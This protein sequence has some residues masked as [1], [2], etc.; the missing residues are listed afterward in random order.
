MAGLRLDGQ[1]ATDSLRP[2]PHGLDAKLGPAAVGSPRRVESLSVVGDFDNKLAAFVPESDVGS[3]DIGVLANVGQRLL[4]N[5]KHL[6]V[7]CEVKVRMVADAAV[8]LH[9]EAGHPTEMARVAV[10]AVE[11][12]PLAVYRRAQAKNSLAHVR[13]D[14]PRGVL[15]GLQ[16]AVSLISSPRSDQRAHCHRLGI[17]VAE[18]LGEAV[19]ELPSDALTLAQGRGVQD[20]TVEACVFDG[21]CQPVPDRLKQP[22]L[23]AMAG[24]P[25]I[26][27]PR[28][29]HTEDAQYPAALLEWQGQVRSRVVA[30]RADVGAIWDSPDRGLTRSDNAS[31]DVVVRSQPAP[32]GA[33]ARAGPVDAAVFANKPDFRGMGGRDRQDGLK[34]LR[35]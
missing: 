21:E 9:P 10:K 23:I 34:R 6:D 35:Q 24:L 15:H 12:A 5:S 17:D 31:H 1:F 32:F 28:A 22:A 3:G 13:I 29:E 26:G 30:G 8:D 33:P 16:L 18:H 7:G 25:A 4:D 14:G 27:P 11:K 20:A 2:L 19:V